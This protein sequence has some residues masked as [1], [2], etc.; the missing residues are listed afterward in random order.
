MKDINIEKIGA[1]FVV[2]AAIYMFWQ[3]QMDIKDQIGDL[4]E[5]T[6]A[7]EVK[8]ERVEVK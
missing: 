3:S 4:R 1:Y 7:L 2:L 8:I 6:R 5:R